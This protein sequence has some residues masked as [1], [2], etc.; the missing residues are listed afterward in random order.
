[1]PRLPKVNLDAAIKTA[2]TSKKEKLSPIEAA[3]A[4]IEKAFGNNKEKDKSK[5]LIQKYSDRTKEHK[6]CISFGDAAVDAASNC[7]G[8][9]RGKMV[10]IFGPESG[11]KSLLSL[12]LIA[13]A[14]KQGLVCCLADI[15][16]SFDPDWARQNGVD[17]DNL[18]VIDEPMSAENAMNYV[19]GLCACGKFG[20]VVVDST[21]ALVPQQEL[22]GS[23][24][25]QSY[26]LLARVMSKACRQIMAN[27]GRT[28]TT[29][30]FI[31]QIRDKMNSTG[32]GDTT[33]TPGGKAL[34]FYCHQRIRVVPGETIT[35][36]EGEVK[37]VVARE[38]YVTFVKNKVARPF[39]AC[40][41]R[42]VFDAAML[43]PVVKL[44]SLARAKD[45]KAIRMYN[46]V[47]T[48]DKDLVE[49]AKK[50]VDTG[51]TNIV[52]LANYIIKENLVI[53]IL[54]HCI[55]IEKDLPEDTK[56]P[57]IPKD[58]KDMLDDPSLIVSPG[59]T[60]AK[61]VASGEVLSDGSN[62]TESE[63]KSEDG[64]EL[65]FEE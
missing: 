4:N 64:S 28:A 53:P 15:E 36:A 11:G 13:S 46:G 57:K 59:V 47:F 62:A 60:P 17:V 37:V 12:R 42:I 1:M 7:K 10:E 45:Y 25:D 52:A 32:R 6:E 5:F 48:I 30:V 21:A 27:C 20:L 3:I 8:V 23:I 9:P 58:V 44:C 39:G 61:V 35:V 63:I 26:A 50:N 40:K 43:N 51:A 41:M 56:A 49:D 14:Q 33:T 65:S 55:E 29:C 22:E 24:E 31:N 54:E 19:N 38:S 16:Q 2:A 18:Y 34:K